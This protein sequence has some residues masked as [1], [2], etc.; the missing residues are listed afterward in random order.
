MAN[1]NTKSLAEFIKEKIAE[2]G[3]NDVFDVVKAQYPKVSDWE[4]RQRIM[5]LRGGDVVTLDERSDHIN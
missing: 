1:E 5:I 2:L 3:E 4:I